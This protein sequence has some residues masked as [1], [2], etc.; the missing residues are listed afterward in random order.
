MGKDGRSK[1]DW[2]QGRKRTGVSHELV[3]DELR[4]EQLAHREDLPARHAQEERHRV[5]HVPQHEL[6]RQRVDPEALADPRQ[7]PVDRRDERDDREHVRGRG[8]RAAPAAGVVIRPPQLAGRSD[9]ARYHLGTIYWSRTCEQR[10]HMSVLNV[11]S[12]L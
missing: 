7:Q 9:S 4:R 1:E 8:R 2:G 12:L 11:E 3:L 10:D 5:E 6:Q